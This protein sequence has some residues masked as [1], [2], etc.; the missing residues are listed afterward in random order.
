MVVTVVNSVV[1][2]RALVG[3]VVVVV[4]FI[5]VVVV[6]GFD[7]TADEAGTFSVVLREVLETSVGAAIGDEAVS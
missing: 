1:D 7:V 3:L 4:T 6:T 5:V 2:I